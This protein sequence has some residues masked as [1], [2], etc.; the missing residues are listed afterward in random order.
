MAS[1]PDS[2]ATRGSAALPTVDLHG[3]RLHA[4]TEAECVEHIA[5]ALE[6]GRGGWVVTPNLDHMR[7]L[8]RHAPYREL[9]AH[10]TLA[11]ADGMP[12][13]WASRLQRTPLPGRV[14]GSHL[15]SSL[16]AALAR[17]GRSVFLLG[18]DPGT[19]D[20]AARVLTTRYP[21]LVIA[22]THCPAHGFES[23]ARALAELDVAFAAVRPDVVLVGLGSPKQELLIE[24]LRAGHPATWWLGIGI[25][26][27]FVSGAVKPAPLW[28]QKLGLEWTHRLVQEP[29]RLARRYLIDGL[30][31]AFVLLSTAAWRGLRSGIRA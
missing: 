28:M 22:G 3:V 5:Q 7:R 30:P 19:A 24:R 9:C 4:I 16:S 29:S 1:G 12:L 23:D 18:G 15:I 11:V 8:V 31:F 20:A 17:R 21:G 27:S 25:S 10:A 2:T 26:F 14:A 6:A 13:V